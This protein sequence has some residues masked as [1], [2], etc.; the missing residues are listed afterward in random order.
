MYFIVHKIKSNIWDLKLSENLNSM[1]ISRKREMDV[2]FSRMGDNVGQWRLL[3]RNVMFNTD[4]TSL[5]IV[6]LILVTY[7]CNLHLKNTTECKN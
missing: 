4:V 2:V 5:L 7:V 1:C 3:S 6:K